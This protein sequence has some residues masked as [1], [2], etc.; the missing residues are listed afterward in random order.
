[1]PLNPGQRTSSTS[2]AGPQKLHDRL[3]AARVSLHPQMQGAKAAVDEE[4]IERP[5][6]GADGVLHEAQALVP[7]RIA[8][9]D[10]AADDVGVAAQVL[11]SSSA[12]RSAAPCS[13]G[14]WLTGVAKVLS[15]A[16]KRV[17]AHGPATAPM[18]TTSRRGLV[19][20][21]DPDQPRVVT[22]R[23]LERVEV[24]LV[25]E[26]VGQAPARQHLVDEPVGPAVEVGRQDDVRAR[27]A[28]D[29]DQ[30]VLRREP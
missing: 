18:S 10:D 12:R 11:A 14:R 20:R 9:D 30:R 24:G 19:G 8:R 6:H 1:M 28:D 3:R 2:G 17:A 21:L 5:R 29:G 16:T 22:D 15:T 25:D 13:S 27:L 4:A 23:A 26:V 7:C